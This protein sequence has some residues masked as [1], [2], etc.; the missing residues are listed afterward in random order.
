MKRRIACLESSSLDFR[1]AVRS[2]GKSPGFV[3][4]VALSLAL[5]IGAN[6]TIFSVLDVLLLRPLTY[7]HPQQLVTI[8]E[9]QLIGIVVG[10]VLALGLMRAISAVLF[11]VMSTDPQTYLMVAGVERD[12]IHRLLSTR[13]SGDQ[14]RSH[15]CAAV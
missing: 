14:G 5:G 12:C 15:R 4:V 10:V 6:R 9:T 13:A 1:L 2:L 11:G 7:D 3:T 8:S